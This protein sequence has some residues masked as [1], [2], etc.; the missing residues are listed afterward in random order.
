MQKF[1]DKRVS[2]GWWNRQV[3]CRIPIY[4]G[5]F[6]IKSCFLVK[7]RQLGKNF[8]AINFVKTHCNILKARPQPAAFTRL[9]EWRTK[10]SAL[11]PTL[12]ARVPHSPHVDSVSNYLQVVNTL[13]HFL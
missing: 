1:L 10:I 11:C 3:L 7:L 8:H 5:G 4:Q 2:Q 12:Q 9:E 13:Q 6:V